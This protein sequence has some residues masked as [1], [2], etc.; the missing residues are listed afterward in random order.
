VGTNAIQF[1][2]HMP[3]LLGQPIFGMGSQYP[4]VDQ[5]EDEGG[6]FRFGRGMAPGEL[7]KIG[8]SRYVERAF[9]QAFEKLKQLTD[10]TQA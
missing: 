6:N 7:G 4:Q 2:F 8:G 3:Y 5:K 9:Y 1:D 10:S